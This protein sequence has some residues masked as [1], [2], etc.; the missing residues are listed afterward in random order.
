MPHTPPT[1][2][3]DMLSLLKEY[4]YVEQE[5]WGQAWCPECGGIKPGTSYDHESQHAGHREDCHLQATIAL[6]EA[7]TSHLTPEA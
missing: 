5:D 3:A 7:H 2:F 1:L 6:A 4:Q